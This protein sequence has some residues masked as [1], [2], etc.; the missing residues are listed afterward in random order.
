[1]SRLVPD[2]VILGLI[3]H[4]P[5]HGYELLNSFR[6]KSDLGRIWTMSTSQLY[7]V[8]KR[9]E[10]KGYVAGEQ[11][12]VFDAP[13]RVVYTLTK[14]GERQLMRWLYEEKPHASIHKTRVMFLS[15]LYIAMLLRLPFGEII[16]NQKKAFENQKKV[17]L[18]EKQQAST[19]IENLTIDF[20][21]NQI[22]SAI[23][24]IQN[25]RVIMTKERV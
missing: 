24:W 7:A 19:L 20:V 23:N 8:L 13:A 6:V 4:Q 21:I 14:S 5:S 15:R 17:F 9:L 25:C 16:E 11:E 3:K 22:E 10:A 18:E 2:H 1:M 12:D